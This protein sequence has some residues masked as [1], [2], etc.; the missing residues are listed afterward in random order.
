MLIVIDYDETYTAAP[1]LWDN[2]ICAAKQ[3]DC[4]IVCCTM[5]FEE[6]GNLNRDVIAD[7][8]KHGIEIIY[9]ANHRDK[10][11]AIK[12]AGYMPENAIWIDDRPMYIFMHRSL[13]ELP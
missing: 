3:H 12:V 13:D 5:R 9:A 10:W 1:A 8:G 4:T 11:E 6:P 2:F 7:M